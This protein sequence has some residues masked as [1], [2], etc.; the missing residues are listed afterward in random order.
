[1]PAK[2]ATPHKAPPASPRKDSEKRVLSLDGEGIV[3]GIRRL[4]KIKLHT[5]GRRR[6]QMEI[7]IHELNRILSPIRKAVDGVGEKYAVPGPD[8]PMPAFVPPKDDPRRTLDWSRYAGEWKPGQYAPGSIVLYS[9][10]FFE[11]EDVTEEQPTGPT[12]RH[13]GDLGRGH[14]IAEYGPWKKEVD[15]IEGETHEV[16]LYILPASLYD[17]CDFDDVWIEITDLGEE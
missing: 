12:W 6:L 11:A 7:N 3:T 14:E 8:G 2:K 16:E 10:R 15:E 4:E 5:K 17:A 1:M 9:N 13:I